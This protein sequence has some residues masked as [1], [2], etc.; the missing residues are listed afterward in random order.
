MI[1]SSDETGGHM[2]EFEVAVFLDRRLSPTERDRV[3]AHLAICADCRAEIVATGELLAWSKRRRRVVIGAGTLAIAATL[4]LVLRPALRNEPGSAG[5]EQVRDASAVTPLVAYGPA[6]DQ[7]APP[8]RFVWASAP[9]ASAYRLSVTDANGAPVWTFTAADTSA[10][11]PDSVTLAVGV[12]YFWVVDAMLDD[13]TTRSTELR[14]FR[15]AQ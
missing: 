10:A 12:A 11:L 14:E 5:N 13:G 6:G 15:P 1:P 7:T 2:N 3:D 8:L 4:L 9:R